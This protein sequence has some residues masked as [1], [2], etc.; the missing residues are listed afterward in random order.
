MEPRLPRAV[1]DAHLA[2]L[3]RRNLR[4]STIYQRSRALARL[5]AQV[6][7]PVLELTHLEITEALDARNVEAA[8]RRTEISHL[9]RFYEW[10]ELEGFVARTPMLRVIRPRVPRRLP[11]P[12][13]DADLVAAVNGA[14][15]RI[16]PVLLLA[17]WAGLRACEIAQLRAEHLVLGGGVPV[18]I[19][20]VGKG[21]GASAVPLH[22]ELVALASTLPRSGW[23]IP[24]LDG[25]VGPCAPHRISSLANNYLHGVGID[26]TLHTLRHWFGT[27][28]Y[29]SSGG[30]LRATQEGLRHLS[31]VSTAGYTAIAGGTISAA[32]G[33]IPGLGELPAA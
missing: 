10:A 24:R 11:R 15:D 2:D 6:D 20:D 22:P 12:M 32:V 28:L 13:P 17:A 1:L 5:A 25:R 27:Q 29:R 26:H 21:G 9:A 7:R 18:L 4:P 19:V 23:L 30:D 33:A 16:R 31:P 14:P 8:S 3:R